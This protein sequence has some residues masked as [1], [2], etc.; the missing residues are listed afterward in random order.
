[1]LCQG[2]NSENVIARKCLAV[3]IVSTKS[4]K[5]SSGMKRDRQCYGMNFVL[6]LLCGPVESFQVCFET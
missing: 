4:T 6:C 5:K 1:M 3:A 2:H